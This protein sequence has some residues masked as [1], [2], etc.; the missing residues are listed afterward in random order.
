MGKA[1]ETGSPWTDQEIDLVVAAYFDLLVA[2]LRGERPT[3]ASRVRDLQRLIPARSTGSIEFKMGNISAVLEE[4][5]E[6]WIDGYKPY[7][8]Y[9]QRLREI[10]VEWLGPNQRIG[11]ILAEYQA[12]AI[13]APMQTRRPID[14]LLVPPPSMERGARRGSIGLTTGAFGAIRDLQ[15]RRLG[16]AGEELVLDAERIGLDRRGR[17]DLAKRVRWVAAEVATE[18]VMTSPRFGPMARRCT[19]KSRRRT[20]GCG[21]R[22]TSHAGKS[23]PPSANPRSGRSTGCSTSIATRGSIGLMGRSRNQPR[24]CPRCTSASPD[25]GHGGRTSIRLRTRLAA[26]SVG[27]SS[28]LAKLSARSRFAQLLTSRDRLSASCVPAPP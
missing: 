16:R 23:Q 15:N 22:S 11:Q 12:N 1:G 3:K 14:D 17:A 13:P 19:S 4:L 24:S 8:N 18:R 28:Q 6:P 20:L 10:V 25:D 5:Q 21:R 9:Q 26:T 2:E 27:R 7:P